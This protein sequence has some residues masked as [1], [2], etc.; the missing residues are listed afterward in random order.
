MAIKQRV[1][2]R[3]RYSATPLFILQLSYPEIALTEDVITGHVSYSHSLSYPPHR[4]VRVIPRPGPDILAGHV[5]FKL[6][7]TDTSSG[8]T[9]RTSFV[10]FALTK[11]ELR[12]QTVSS[13]IE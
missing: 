3:P 7:V 12:H 13:A 8:V 11:C 10:P 9:E 5:N 6:S 4:V 1:R 2:T